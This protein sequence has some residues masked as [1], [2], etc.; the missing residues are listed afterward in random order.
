MPSAS[1]DDGEI[2]PKFD[3]KTLAKGHEYANKFVYVL[4]RALVPFATE[5][6]Y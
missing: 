6:C 1:Y 5:W 2:V 3:F 4:Y